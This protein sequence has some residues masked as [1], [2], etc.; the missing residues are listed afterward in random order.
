MDSPAI[1]L[2]RTMFVRKWRVISAKIVNYGAASN[3]DLQDN[4][5]GGIDADGTGFTT[6]QETGNKR[7]EKGAGDRKKGER[8]SRTYEHSLSDGRKGCQISVTC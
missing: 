4:F 6:V 5:A 1:A 3:N 8:R 7:P 2:C